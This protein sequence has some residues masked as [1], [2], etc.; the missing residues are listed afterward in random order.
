MFAVF[1]WLL[2]LLVALFACAILFFVGVLSMPSTAVYHPLQRLVDKNGL[3]IE[4]AM[5][6]ER[7]PGS[8]YYAVYVHNEVQESRAYS[9]FDRPVMW[10]ARVERD[11]LRLRYDGRCYVL[12][13]DY[14]HLYYITR[15]WKDY[16]RRKE[17]CFDVVQLQ[18]ATKAH[19]ENK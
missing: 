6:E 1:R 17:L 3:I 5:I 14:G 15:A 19:G 10:L 13:A 4:L 11:S 7:G 9:E 18:S 16:L 2:Y 8:F 12:E